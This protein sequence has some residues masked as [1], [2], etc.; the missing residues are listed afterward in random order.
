MSSDQAVR[1][2]AI[3]AQRDYET[4][5]AAS[6]QTAKLAQY[7]SGFDVTSEAGVALKWVPLTVTQRV[8]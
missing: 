4:N 8:Q 1:K 2:H 7:I 5:R 3:T 6:T